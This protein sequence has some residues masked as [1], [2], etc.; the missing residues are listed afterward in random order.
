MELSCLLGITRRVPQ[1][2]FCR[3][4]YNKSFID[5]ACSFKMAGYWPG[6]F[7]ASLQ[8]ST[9]KKKKLGQYPA[10][11]TSHLVNNPYILPIRLVIGL[12]IFFARLR[13]STPSQYCTCTVRTV[14]ID[15]HFCRR[16]SCCSKYGPRTWLVTVNAL[17]M[18]NIALF[19]SN[20]LAVEMFQGIFH[21]RA[22]AK[23][24][25]LYETI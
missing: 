24:A 14:S 2:K 10:I 18:Y 22:Q 7:F 13:T 4:P 16:K 20:R 25:W 15:P 1:E 19:P 17:Y 11:L 21:L 5:Q 8:T 23:R 9:R 3:K 12:D 6:S